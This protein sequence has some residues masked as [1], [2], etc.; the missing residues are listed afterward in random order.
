MIN[1]HTRGNTKYIKSFVLKEE[2]DS[3]TNRKKWCWANE[4]I[5]HKLNLKVNFYPQSWEI[6]MHKSLWVCMRPQ[7]STVQNSGNF[8]QIPHSLFSPQV[9]KLL[10]WGRTGANALNEQMM[11]FFE[12]II[13]EARWWVRCWFRFVNLILAWGTFSTVIQILNEFTSRQATL[14]WILPVMVAS[15]WGANTT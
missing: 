11:C 2:S 1:N 6:Q 7:P 10:I 5:V 15:P 3:V 14:A 4:S 13:S 8:M 12:L 9:S